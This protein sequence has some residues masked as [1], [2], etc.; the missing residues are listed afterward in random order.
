MA[1]ERGLEVLDFEFKFLSS[2]FFLFYALR[3]A[4]EP[5]F[6]VILGTGNVLANTLENK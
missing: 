6:L 5:S 1:Y 4:I 3:T 2:A